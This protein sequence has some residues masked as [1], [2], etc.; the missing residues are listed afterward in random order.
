MQAG[1]VSEILMGDSTEDEID[2][3]ITKLEELD[4][5]HTNLYEHVDYETIDDLLK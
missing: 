1:K 4:R 5:F 3:M 2:A